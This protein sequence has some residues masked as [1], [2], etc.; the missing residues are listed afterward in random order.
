MVVGKIL[1][2]DSFNFGYDAI[3]DYAKAAVYSLAKMG[4]VN[5]VGGNMFAPFDTA[6]RAM[7]AKVIY[8]MIG[9]LK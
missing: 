5:G 1:E 4:I 2:N 8:G 3:A 9:G 6:T 7:A